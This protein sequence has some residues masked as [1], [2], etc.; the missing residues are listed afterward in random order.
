M[1]TALT[2]TFAAIQAAKFYTAAPSADCTRMRGHTAHELASEWLNQ[3]AQLGDYLQRTQ[4]R[5]GLHP[6]INAQTPNPTVSATIADCSYRFEFMNNGGIKL[7][8]VNK[9][10]G[11]LMM[12]VQGPA[13][14]EKIVDRFGMAAGSLLRA[15]NDHIAIQKTAA[16]ETA[17]GHLTA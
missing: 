10:A 9:G 11:T 7:G 4:T 8:L 2:A 5:L 15:H 6:S 12:E 13:E 14:F 17:I 16:Y 3:L 1:R